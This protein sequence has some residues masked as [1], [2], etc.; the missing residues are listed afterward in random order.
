MKDYGREENGGSI[1]MASCVDERYPPENMLDGKDSTYWMTTGMFPQEF[2]LAVSKPI[3]VSK[4]T[5]LSLNGQDPCTTNALLVTLPHCQ[6]S[7]H[8][9]HCV[10]KRYMQDQTTP[11]WALTVFALFRRPS[12]CGPSACGPRACAPPQCMSPTPALPA[13]AVKKLSVE[14]REQENPDSFE[15]AFEVGEWMRGSPG[16]GGGGLAWVVQLATGLTA[17]MPSENPPHFL[18]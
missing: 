14:W 1:V 8:C 11:P 3:H 10:R 2:V 15:K 6:A 18:N 16:G 12:A 7:G 17:L 5:T 13:C 4:I 9:I